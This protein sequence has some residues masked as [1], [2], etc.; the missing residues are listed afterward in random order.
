MSKKKRMGKNKSTSKGI[1]G[2]PA[3]ARTSFGM[4]RLLNQL[5]AHRAGKKV[6]VVRP[7]KNNG[8][9][10]FETVSGQDMWGK[11]PEERKRSKKKSNAS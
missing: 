6:R 1:V 4:K 8:K 9:E 5:D 3:K 2:S 11:T 7:T 10:Q